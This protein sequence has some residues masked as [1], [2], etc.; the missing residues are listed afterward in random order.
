MGRLPFE[1]ERSRPA[2]FLGRT[3][4][5]SASSM[6]AADGLEWSTGQA[7]QTHQTAQAH[8]EWQE[9]Q[10]RAWGKARAS[11]SSALDGLKADP[12]SKPLASDLRVI[13]RQVRRID[14]RVGL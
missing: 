4:G 11:I 8:R 6:F 13:E 1:R 5:Y 9:R 10:R 3:H 12:A 14:E 2:C 7:E